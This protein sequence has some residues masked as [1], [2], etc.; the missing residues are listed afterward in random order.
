MASTRGCAASA[1]APPHHQT[2]LRSLDPLKHSGPA[3]LPEILAT[4]D[5]APAQG[6][7]LIF[8]PVILLDIDGTC[9]PM[10]AC[11][12]LPRQWAPWVRSQFG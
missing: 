8:N 5:I 6:D 11:D 7:L 4:T 10:C 9:S 12:L 1:V 2:R 3:C